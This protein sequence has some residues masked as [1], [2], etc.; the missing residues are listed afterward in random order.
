MRITIKTSIALKSKEDRGRNDGSRKAR[1]S[2]SAQI[3]ST[4]IRKK[5]ALPAIKGKRSEFETMRGVRGIRKRP[6]RVV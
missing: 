1:I 2:Q 5:K 3:T 6:V 4:I